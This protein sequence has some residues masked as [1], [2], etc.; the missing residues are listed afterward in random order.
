MTAKPFPHASWI[1]KTDPEGRAWTQRWL[2]L[3]IKSYTLTY[4]DDDNIRKNP[5]VKGRRVALS[6]GVRL[7]S[8]VP[9]AGRHQLARRDCGHRQ[10][11]PCAAEHS[12]VFSCHP[13][14]HLPVLRRQR[15]ELSLVVSMLAGCV[16]VRMNSQAACSRVNNLSATL[17]QCKEDANKHMLSSDMKRPYAGFL[18]KSDPRGKHWKKRWVVLDPIKKMVSYFTKED[19]KT[20]KGEFSMRGATYVAGTGQRY[21]QLCLRGNGAHY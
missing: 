16:V 18:R 4:F 7:S 11:Q 15:R 8:V 5:K 10:Q 3:D 21:H 9:C 6:R 19:K 2:V 13:W 14:P 12:S 1:L 17:R 20:K